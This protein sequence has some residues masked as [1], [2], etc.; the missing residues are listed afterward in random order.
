MTD[1]GRMVDSLCSQ[2]LERVYKGIDRRCDRFLH[3]KARS[4]GQKRRWA[5]A[6]DKP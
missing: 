2:A 4:E 5:R 1:L 6:K 3:F